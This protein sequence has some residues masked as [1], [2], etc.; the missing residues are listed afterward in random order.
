MKDILSEVAEMYDIKIGGVPWDKSKDVDDIVVF[1]SEAVNVMGKTPVRYIGHRDIYKDGC[2]GTHIV[3]KKGETQLVPDDKAVLM[4]KHK[5][6]Y[7]LGEYEGAEEQ[8]IAEPSEE[9]ELDQVSRE[10][11]SRM[12]RKA[13]ILE[14]AQT[15]FNRPLDKSKKVSEL[16]EET[17]RLIDQYGMP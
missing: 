6:V 4:F 12:N 14:F 8:E 2:F 11:V 5:E 15:N 10:A 9:S 13:P 17:I 1:I 16:Q 3:F 7:E